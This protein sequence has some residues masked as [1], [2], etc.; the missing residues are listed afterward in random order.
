MAKEYSRAERL[1]DELQR[2]L[3]LTIQ[4]EVRDPRVGMVN[5]NE[6]VV[7]RDLSYAKVYV[8]YVN[9]DTETERAEATT[10]LNGAAGFLRSIVAKKLDIR[11]TP[12]LQF[13]F[14]E[15][16]MRGQALSN[17]INKAVASDR[18]NSADD[19]SSE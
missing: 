16:S 11:M 10:A 4:N 14:D 8:T 13:I 7:S 19:D 17:L 15:T 5:I 2:L 6:V 18:A 3:A 12:K 1:G 9:R